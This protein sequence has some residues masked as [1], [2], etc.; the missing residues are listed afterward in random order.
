[1]FCMR[2]KT[3]VENGD[4]NDESAEATDDATLC[5]LLRSEAGLCGPATRSTLGSS[6]V[7]AG[8]AEP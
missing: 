6:H 3:Y 1:M 7:Q 4:A 5:F 2:S 8:L